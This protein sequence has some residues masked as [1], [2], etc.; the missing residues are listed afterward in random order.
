MS[1]SVVDSSGAAWFILLCCFFHSSI[2]FAADG[3]AEVVV[4]A[5]E[6][7]INPVAAEY[8]QD[9]I[10]TAQERNAR[11]LVLRLDTPGGLDTAMRA[12]MPW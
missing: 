2:A 4:A 12:A 6:G 11:A 10:L 3:P 7:V 5:Y 1:R 8:V 9:A